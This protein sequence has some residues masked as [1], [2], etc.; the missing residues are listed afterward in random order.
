M[1]RAAGYALVL[2][3]VALTPGLMQGVVWAATLVPPLTSAVATNQGMAH[4]VEL[5]GQIGGASLAVAVRGDYAYLGVGPR[6]IVLDVRD[7]AHPLKVGET[8]LL[9][10]IVQ[11]VAVLGSHAYVADYGSG[12]RIVDVSD[13]AHPTEVGSYDTPGSASGV[14][15]SGS[16]AYV[17]D[18]DSWYSGL[19]IINVSDPAH[20]REVGSYA[21]PRSA[22]GVAV[23]GSYAYVADSDSWYSGLRIVDVSDPAHPREVGS[24]DT[25]GSAWDVAV[26]GS[27]AYVADRDGGLVM[28]RFLPHR[29]YLP[30]ALRNSP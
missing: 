23:S 7:P 3:C 19:R 22:Q 28:L 10:D 14:A 6:L 24:Y 9:P 30:L 17:A 13:P 20:P 29:P 16:H 27:Y 26:S 18:S 1:K 8:G 11:D 15:V 4:N 12:L 5:V 25:P 2:L 21:T